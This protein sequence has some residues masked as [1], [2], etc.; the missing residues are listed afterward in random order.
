MRKV[1]GD[2]W[3][4]RDE[5][6]SASYIIPVNLV[7]TCGRGIARQMKDRYPQAAN[8]Y[9]KICSDISWWN[10]VEPLPAYRAGGATEIIFFPVKHNWRDAE[11]IRISFG[12][13][14]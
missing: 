14:S 5:V 1:V 12:V 6:D 4:A 3:D 11:Y 7:G 10:R 2:I 9:K 8:W 13:I